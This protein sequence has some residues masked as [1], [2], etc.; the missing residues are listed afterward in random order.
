MRRQE[1]EKLRNLG[2]LSACLEVACEQAHLRENWENE[3]VHTV[4]LW[5]VVMFK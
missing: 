1:F 5:K 3:P 2:L 4:K